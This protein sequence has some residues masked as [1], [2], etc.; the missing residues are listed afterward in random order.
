MESTIW[1]RI[2]VANVIAVLIIIVQAA[3]IGR[4]YSGTTSPARLFWFSIAG[5]AV[6]FATSASVGV[7]H[8]GHRFRPAARWLVEGRQPTA[9]EQV[10]LTR[11]PL[12]LATYPL[13]YWTLLPL[14][15]VPYLHYVVG[16]RP[17]TLAM[18][19]IVVAFALSAIIGVLLGYFLVERTIRPLLAIA[20]SARAPERTKS[21]GLFPRALLAWLAAS[22][23]PL[24]AIGVSLIGL[25]AE[26]RAHATPVV[27]VICVVGALAGVVVAAFAVRAITDPLDKIRDGLRRVEKGDLDFELAVDEGGEIGSL[28]AG[29]NRMLGGLRERVRLGELFGRHVGPEVAERALT[30]DVALGGEMHEATMLFTDVIAS[31]HLAESRTPEEAVAVLN[32]FFEAVVRSVE[33]EG[34]YVN[35][36]QG[37]GALCIFGVP[38]AQEDHADRGLRAARA[39]RTKLIEMREEHGIEAAIGISSGDVVAGNVGTATRY[40]YTVVG[41][42]VNEAARLTERAKAMA[43]LVLASESTIRC[44][45]TE[46]AFWKPTGRLHL[47][48]RAQPTLAFE[49]DST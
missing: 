41:D 21:L 25:D 35:Q 9:D 30:T 47:R 18:V 24:A 34:G 45:G 40:G 33:N 32:A 28:T 3:T 7:L 11:L 1:R 38:S 46:A 22:G 43:T 16:F 23:T 6:Y 17:G 42:P 37:D 44:A 10:D 20:F 14:W 49:P 12:R 4:V 13:I 26:Q 15:A 39:L 2:V 29:F 19:K 8:V 48:G 36:F 31:T 5:A 27:W